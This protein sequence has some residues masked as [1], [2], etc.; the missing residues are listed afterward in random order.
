M[1]HVARRSRP[2]PRRRPVRQIVPEVNYIC[3]AA[4][5]VAALVPTLFSRAGVSRSSL[6]T[7]LADSG[8]LSLTPHAPDAIMPRLSLRLP[9]HQP[10]FRPLREK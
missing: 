10:T 2:K 8:R 3:W 6:P 7:D 9:C 4:D 1:G 5:L